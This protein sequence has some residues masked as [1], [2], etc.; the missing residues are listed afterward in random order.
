[1]EWQE[2]KNRRKDLM[3]AGS[4]S[5][6]D[7]VERTA[8]LQT[9]KSR[10][11]QMV[12]KALGF[13]QPVLTQLQPARQGRRPRCNHSALSSWAAPAPG[14]GRR[15]DLRSRGWGGEH[16]SWLALGPR[17]AL[18]ARSWGGGRRPWLAPGHRRNF[19]VAAEGKA[20]DRS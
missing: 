13:Q 20:A 5:V 9:Q 12:R 17:H 11:R 6:L 18:R 2:K 15:R 3:N 10:L 14:P 16:R 4:V 8:N 1:M 7:L 19:A